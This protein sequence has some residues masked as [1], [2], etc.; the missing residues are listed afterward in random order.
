MISVMSVNVEEGIPKERLSRLLVVD[1]EE[2][3][4]VTVSEVLRREGFIV[5]M[6][7]NGQE[8]LA[9][10]Q[11]SHYD[12][13]LTDLHME[14]IDGISVLAEIHS[15]APTTISIVLT[16]FASLESAIAAMRHGAYDYLIKPCNIED[17]IHTVQRGLSHRRLIL[18]ER[19]A[20]LKLERLNSEL[21]RRVEDRTAEL[22]R[23]NE[24]LSEANRA[25]DLFLASL[26][27]ELRTPLS[28]ILGW[29]R[30]LRSGKTDPAL[31]AK[32]LDVIERNAQLQAHLIDDLL[33][34]SRIVTNKLTIEREPT[35]LRAV[36]RQAVETVLDRATAQGISLKVDLT[37]G[38]VIVQGSPMRL[39]QIIWNFLTN[40]IKF[41]ESSGEV[42]VKC[43]SEG[44][45]CYVTVSDTG[46][47]IA[48]EF[49]PRIFE[50]FSQSDSSITNKQE[51]LGL[52]LAIARKLAE[53]QDGQ[54]RAESKGLGKGAR[55]TLVLPCAAE[56]DA[57][58]EEA[59]ALRLP[60]TPR[61]VLVID[62]STDTLEM[63]E[64]MLTHAGC[65]VVAADSADAALKLA[66]ADAPGIIISDIGIPEMDGFELLTRLR[67]LPGLENIPAIAVSGYASEED[68]ARA[69]EVGF[70]AH[71]SKPI[72]F[73]KLFELIQNLV[74]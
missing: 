18:S 51:G 25:K 59:E 20:R 32:G 46:L 56:T 58:Q 68:V 53:L 31:I 6:A 38:P 63:L 65:R 48:P 29:T 55:F 1:D 14:G 73:D 11:R 70:S 34:V 41:T 62:D 21:E 4:A 39:Q 10:L 52:G 2:S 44:G 15:I 72:D 23:V 45:E 33:D 64:V 50:P 19:E 42:S 40:A 27:H 8:A 9:Y 74:S 47:G 57:E 3:V 61:L 7:M 13:V 66:L 37:N 5:D 22:Q 35:D 67:R 60:H 17:M 16:G 12:L 43:Y 26:S 36:V 69:L 28:P 49:L 54:V 71:L 30:I 24:E